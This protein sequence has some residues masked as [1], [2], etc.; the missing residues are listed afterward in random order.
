MNPLENWDGTS[1]IRPNLSLSFLFKADGQGS[2]D[3]RDLIS[4]VNVTSK[5]NSPS[6]H[7]IDLESMNL[8]SFFEKEF[9]NLIEWNSK[10]NPVK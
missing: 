5:E 4:M 10:L 9:E 3:N 6:V 2:H 8:D 1:F 7:K